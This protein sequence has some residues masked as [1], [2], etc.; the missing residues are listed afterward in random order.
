MFA[1]SPSGLV[2]SRA[3]RTL[4]SIEYAKVK[5]IS[6]QMDAFLP[7]SDKPTAAAI[8][9]HGGGW[10]RGDRRVDV[11]PLFAPLSQA[12]I[13]WFSIDYRL[14]KNITQFGVAVADVQAAIRFIKA[15]SGD[16]NIDPGRLSIVGESAGGQLAAMA[17]LTG[18]PAL[19]VSTFVGLYIPSDLV[20][21]MKEARYIPE[22][23]RRTIVGK[24]WEKLVLSQVAKLSPLQNLAP[25]MP[26]TLL[27]HGTADPLVPYNQSVALCD[28]I[29]QL[30]GYC[31]LYQVPGA[32]HGIRWWDDTTYQARLVKWIS[33]SRCL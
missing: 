12:R 5:G 22:D 31:E 13:A 16:Y 28:R 23:L 8:I 32:G 14:A 2:E 33:G 17:I 9:V 27:I 6:L 19:R 10:V 20:T 11:Q 1:V 29:N 21:L 30:G 4:Q 15:R 24:P 25:A 18:K 26:P 3:A 7:A